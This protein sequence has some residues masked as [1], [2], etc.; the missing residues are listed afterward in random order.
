MSLKKKG[1]NEADTDSIISK[2]KDLSKE[3]KIELISFFINELKR[4]HQV[5]EQEIFQKKEISIPAGVFSND[6]LSSLEAIVKYMKEE[7]KLRFSKI[8]KLLNRSNKTI[9]TTY[10]KAVKKMPYPFGFISRDI[11]IPVSAISN[12]SFSTLESVVGFIK[13]LDHSNHEVALMLHLDDRTIWTV[14]DRVKKK[15][16]M[17][18]D[19]E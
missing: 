5:S 4:L 7:L 6:K 11:L 14:Y 10:S 15:R 9:W 19:T 17:K 18:L 1:E 2:F 8:G 12:R 3:D 13:D 16:G